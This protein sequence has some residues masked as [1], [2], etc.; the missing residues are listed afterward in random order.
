MFKSTVK[1]KIE[2]I[3]PSSNKFFATIGNSDRDRSGKVRSPQ[4]AP[5]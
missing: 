4:K 5:K 1:F 3:L 2:L